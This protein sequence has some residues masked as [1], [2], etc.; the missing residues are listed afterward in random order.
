MM[1]TPHI[2]DHGHI[3]CD[4]LRDTEVVVTAVTDDSVNF[5]FETD[6]TA[7]EW[8]LGMA[9]FDSGRFVEMDSE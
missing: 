8:P 6:T 2:G 1:S 7:A 9:A 5:R 3:V 4:V